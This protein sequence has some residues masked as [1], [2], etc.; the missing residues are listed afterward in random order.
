[1]GYPLLLATAWIPASFDGI[2][3]IGLPDQ[4]TDGALAS[5]DRLGAF[6]S[7]RRLK[8]WAAKAPR[9]AVDDALA[10]LDEIAR[11]AV[12]KRLPMLVAG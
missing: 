3:A 5:V 10:T 4:P 6:L 9:D 11:F 12:E 2:L 8:R 1:A 7:A